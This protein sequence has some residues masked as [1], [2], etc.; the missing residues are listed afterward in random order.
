MTIINNV[1]NKSILATTLVLCSSRGEAGRVESVYFKL[2][3]C[4]SL[5]LWIPPLKRF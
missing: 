3:L 2:I 1:G 5:H 4:M